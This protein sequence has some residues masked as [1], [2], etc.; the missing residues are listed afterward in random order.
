LRFDKE[1]GWEVVPRSQ[2]VLKRVLLFFVQLKVMKAFFELC[3]DKR[4][5][6]KLYMVGGCRND[7]NKGFPPPFF[8]LFKLRSCMSFIRT[9]QICFLTR[10]APM[11]ARLP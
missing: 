7:G 11:I 3:P 8:F 2:R 9:S 4:D 5:V 6:V 1:N 10:P